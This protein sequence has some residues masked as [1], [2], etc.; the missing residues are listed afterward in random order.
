MHRT[1]PL[2]KVRVLDQNQ[3]LRQPLLAPPK[4]TDLRLHETQVSG[5]IQAVESLVE[6]IELYL[7]DTQVP[8]D[9][10]AVESLVDP[11]YLALENKVSGEPRPWLPM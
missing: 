3:P 5:D 10:K 7:V 4:L 11:A 6:L 8:G 9:I 2:L 1:P